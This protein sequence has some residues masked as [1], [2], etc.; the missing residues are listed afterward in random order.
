VNTCYRAICHPRCRH[1]RL[2]FNGWHWAETPEG[3]VDLLPTFLC[4]DCHGSVD[5]D[6]ALAVGASILD[7]GAAFTAATWASMIEPEKRV[8]AEM[9][10]EANHCTVP[11][12]CADRRVT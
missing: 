12:W 10:F 1:T 7:A 11:G 9:F 8:R 4:R 5:L 2:T 6:H 3:R